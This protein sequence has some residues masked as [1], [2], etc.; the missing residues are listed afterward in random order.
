MK[1]I[2]PLIL[3]LSFGLIQIK[4]DKPSDVVNFALSKVGC[5]YV[6]GTS[7]QIL[8][9]D[10]L[11]T[12]V[13]NGKGNVDPNR[14]RQWMGLQVFDCA[15]LVYAAFNTIGIQLAKGATS[16]WDQ[17]KWQKKGEIKNL[18]TD[19]VCIL[20]RKDGGSMGHTGIYIKNGQFVHAKGS[21]YGVRK[22][23]MSGS[24]WTHWGIPK[25]LYPDEQIKQI[26]NSYPC[27]ARV[28]N[29][30][31]T[32]N[33]RKGPSKSYDLVD[34][35]KVGEVVTLNGYENGWYNL[36]YGKKKGYMM[37]EYLKAL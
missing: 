22:E 30:S 3:L 37:A 32:V 26:C 18:P 7:G 17:T 20:F 33:L 8:T 14:V 34:K 15:G 16:I 11:K 4:T 9:E 31:G 13:A 24:S 25:G 35:I 27:Q 12:F 28:A 29:A 6:W 21:D 36:T 1:Y 2:L 19:K 23:N 10:N 5:G